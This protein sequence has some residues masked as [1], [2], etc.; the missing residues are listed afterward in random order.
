MLS[1]CQADHRYTAGHHEGGVEANTKLA[2]DVDVLGLVVLFKLQAAAAGNGAQVLLQFLLGHADAVVGE[3]DGAVGL[4]QIQP[5]F[6][7]LFFGGNTVVGQAFEIQLVDGIA[8]V[9]NQ[10]PQ[11]NLLVG[12]DGMNHHI[13]QFFAFGLKLLNSHV[14][15]SLLS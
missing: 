13:Q 12:I 10:L 2:N 6:V 1:H 11:K 15:R 3:G 9:G 7:V 8:G 14:K 5:D 4:V